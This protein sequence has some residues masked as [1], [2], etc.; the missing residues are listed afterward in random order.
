MIQ[1]TDLVMLRLCPYRFYLERIQKKKAPTT[2]EM[3]LGTVYHKI[4]EE[5]VRR[6]SLIITELKEGC[7]PRQIFDLL[8]VEY[9]RVIRNVI[10]R[11]KTKLR[12]LNIDAE[13][14]SQELRE[15]YKEIA[16]Q[17]ALSVKRALEKRE[18]EVIVGNVEYRIEDAELELLGRV[19]RIEIHGDLLLPVEIKTVEKKRPTFS[20]MLQLA[21]YALLLERERCT[22]VNKGIIEYPS[23]RII[24]DI[25]DK[26]KENVVNLRDHA[27]K[28]LAGEVPEKVRTDK[29]D[30]CQF[31][32]VCWNE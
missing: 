23:T 2:Q 24:V 16:I 21:G 6:D 26:F 22:V 18:E 31:F 3:Y 15:F 25:P 12:S 11:R 7:K 19:D 13:N 9:C 32:D 8:Y 29:C 14:L 17:K 27:L 20:E 28:I 5:T 10:L 4:A 1:V 30:R